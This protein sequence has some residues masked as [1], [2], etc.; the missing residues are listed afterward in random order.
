MEQPIVE[1]PSALTSQVM[2][3]LVNKANDFA[4]GRFRDKYMELITVADLMPVL[5][6]AIA[7]DWVLMNH[8]WKEDEFKAA[9][10][11]HKIY[12]K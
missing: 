12:E 3:D 8:Q 2:V 7:A 5:I 11:K 9:L 10:F 4:F 1:A 6:S